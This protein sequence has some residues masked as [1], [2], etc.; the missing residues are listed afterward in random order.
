M[1]KTHLQCRE[2][3]KEYEPTFKYVCD[4][5]FG[6]LDVKYNF[7]TISKDKFK[8]RESTY[9]RY[10]ELLPI[11][12]KNNITLAALAEVTDPRNIGSIIRSAASFNIDGLIVKQRHFPD[13]SKLMFKSASGCMEHINIFE[14]ANINLVHLLSINF[15]ISLHLILNE[16]VLQDYP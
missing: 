3:K 5:C 15:F 11:E 14:V 16:L 8:D 1:A 13:N 10:F 4:E 9:W 7:P 12:D 2:C 6:P